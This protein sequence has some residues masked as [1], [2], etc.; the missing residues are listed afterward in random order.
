MPKQG[1]AWDHPRCGTSL[2]LPIQHDLLFDSFSTHFSCLSAMPWHFQCYT[3]C[4]HPL[5]RQQS[6]QLQSF[7]SIPKWRDG[8]LPG[9]KCFPAPWGSQ[10][11]AA[12]IFRGI[13]K[14]TDG[15][16]PG[17]KCLRW[18]NRVAREASKTVKK[19]GARIRKHGMGKP[20][21]LKVLLSTSISMNVI[22]IFSIRT[23]RVEIEGGAVSK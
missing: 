15:T 13:P 4:L 16:L 12:A 23:I 20:R 8:A 9:L 3:W 11:A 10:A 1:G 19:G 6:S 2:F 7:L 22:A 5:P 18:A 17:L 14:R 21:M